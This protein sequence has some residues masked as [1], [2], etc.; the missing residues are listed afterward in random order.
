MDVS[1]QEAQDLVTYQIGA[2]QAFVQAEGGRLRHVKPHGALYN[3]AA[4]DAQLA[5]AVAEA[6]FRVNPEL[7]LVGQSGSEL[8]LA[9]SALGIATASEV[10]ADRNYEPDGTLTSRRS[11]QAM[12]ADPQ[13]AAERVLGMIR[14][15][16]VAAIEGS[17]VAV[18]ADTICVHGDEPGAVALARAMRERLEEAGIVVR[19]F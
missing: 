7:V 10:F 8:I 15:G 5:R 18:E 2:L 4:R 1:P 9:G 13:Q 6:V 17:L 11:T 14:N 19:G 3:M 12:I 16:A